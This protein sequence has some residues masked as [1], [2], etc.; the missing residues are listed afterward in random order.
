[1]EC[2][3]VGGPEV[4]SCLRVLA[5]RNAAES[6]VWK[7]SNDTASAFG[8]L[9]CHCADSV[10]PRRKWPSGLKKNGPNTGQRTDSIYMGVALQLHKASATTRYARTQRQRNKMPFGDGNRLHT[11]SANLRS[12]NPHF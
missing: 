8:Q 4:E 12:L 3:N 11:L 2:F 9:F 7:V 10:S 1:M 5:V 6:W